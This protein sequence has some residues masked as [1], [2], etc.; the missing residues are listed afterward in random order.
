MSQVWNELNLKLMDH[1]GDTM[2][3]VHTHVCQIPKKRKDKSSNVSS[4]GEGKR[5]HPQTQALLREDTYE[6]VVFKMHEK[7]NFVLDVIKL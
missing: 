7:T 5:G 4:G 6:D 1:V 2:H 3:I